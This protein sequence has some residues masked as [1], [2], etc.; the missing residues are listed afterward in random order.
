M[1][2]QT[3]TSCNTLVPGEYLIETLDDPLPG[4]HTADTNSPMLADD[5]WLSAPTNGRNTH[6]RSRKRNYGTPKINIG[7]EERKLH[8][9]SG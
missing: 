5:A 7:I 3:S 1:E 6:W 9:A 4:C 2:S 8:R